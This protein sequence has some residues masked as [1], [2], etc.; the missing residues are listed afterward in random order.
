LAAAASLEETA[1]TL[2]FTVSDTGVGI[3]ADKHASIFN[4]FTRPTPPPP[5]ASGAP[6][7]ASPSPPSSWP[8]WAGG[9]GLRASPDEEAGSTS[10]SP[11]TCPPRAP[12]PALPR[13]VR[14]LERVGPFARAAPPVASRAR[15][16]GQSRQ[17]ARDPAPAGAA[18]PYGD[19]LRRRAGGRRGG[20]GA[21]A[22]PRAD[23]RPMPEMDGFAATAAVRAREAA[24]PGGRPVPSWP[25]PRSR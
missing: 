24:H 8:S 12:A 9:S 19:P 15:G 25:S 18:R 2:H 5:V 4:S 3:P 20:R 6:G 14:D 16:G 11:S 22:G 13:P 1:V 10:P 17:P 7:S 23:G 21:A